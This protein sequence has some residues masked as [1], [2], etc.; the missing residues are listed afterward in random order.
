MEQPSL[1]LAIYY[2]T[3]WEKDYPAELNDFRKFK[4]KKFSSGLI[5][6]VTNG[7]VITLKYF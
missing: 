2:L 3:D 1:V 6:S 4:L 7:K 5:F